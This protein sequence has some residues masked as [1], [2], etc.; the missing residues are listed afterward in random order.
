MNLY[1]RMLQSLENNRSKGVFRTIVPKSQN[2][3]MISIDSKDYLNLSSNDY[4]GLAANKE[5]LDEFHEYAKSQSLRLSSSGSPLLTGAHES[6]ALSC[7]VMETLFGKKATF[8]NSGFSANSGV[9]S[10][11]GSEDTLIIADKLAHASMIDGL[12]ASK[13]KFLRYAHNDYDHL[14]RLIQKSISDYDNI[15]IVTEAVFS[16]DGDRC[17]LKRLIDIKHKY[18]NIYLYIDEAHGFGVLSEDG[19][20][21]CGSL[22]LIDEVD[23]ILTTFGKALASEGACILTNET[24]RDYIINN[25]RPLIFSTALSPYTFA[26]EAFMVNYMK[27]R[28]DL[29]TKLDKISSYIHQTLNECGFDNVSS[30]QIIPLITGDNDRT[31]KASEFFK[32]HGIYAMPIRHPTVPLGKGRLRISLNA[33]LTDTQVE[34]LADT[35]KAFSK[36]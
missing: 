25:S 2:Q 20:G 31:L 3:S 33:G 22:K 15:I 18:Q 8:F 32:A 14:E 5:C 36:D 7:E 21:L 26:H 10:I 34:L 12:T 13:G 30:S 35:I 19:S 28:N 29:R 11:L 1:E 17:D 6:Y 23:F 27:R 24:A 4:L 16:M 9:L